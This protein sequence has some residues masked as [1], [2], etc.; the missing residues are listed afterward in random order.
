MTFTIPLGG[1]VGSPATMLTLDQLPTHGHTVGITDMPITGTAVGS[2]TPKCL[3]DSGDKS[4]PEGNAMAKINNGYASPADATSNMASISG[5][6]QISGTVKGTAIADPIG[7]GKIF[8]NMQ[9]SLGLNW[10]ICVS[11]IYPSF[12]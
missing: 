6:F 4:T 1:A 12:P 10:I 7:N 11:G 3:G 9:P 5:N 8:T 2:I